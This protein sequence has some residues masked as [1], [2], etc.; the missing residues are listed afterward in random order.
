M[1]AGV[2]VI[3]GIIVVF[4]G[5]ALIFIGSILQSTSKTTEV[6]TGGVIMIGP[7]PIIFGNDKGLIITGVILAIVIMVVY[8]ILFYRGGS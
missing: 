3:A 2:L 8:Y 5:I 6:H 7:I 1:N 4:V